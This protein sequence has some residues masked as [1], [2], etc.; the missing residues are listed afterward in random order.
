MTTLQDHPVSGGQTLPQ[1][2][3]SSQASLWRR[4]RRASPFA[5]IYSAA[6]LIFYTIIFI[7]P[8]GTGIWLAFQN[9]DF[10][11]TPKFV[12]LRNFGRAFTDQYFWWAL[13]K[14]LL[15]S[16]VEIALGLSLA[17][18]FALA[19]SQIL[20]KWQNIYL[21]LY[22]LPVITP[23]VVSLYLWRWLYRPTGGAF[24][25]L[26]S[27]LGLPEQPFLASPQQALWAIT[28]V[29]IWAHLGTGIVLFLAG[30]N[31]VPESLFEAARLDGAGFWQSFF[32]I[33][34]PLIRPV[35]VYQMVVSVIGT[36]QMFE[37]FFLIPGPG[38][39]TRTLALYTYELG[40]R[41]LNLGYGAAVSLIIFVM[42]LGAT[43]FQLRRWQ[44]QWEH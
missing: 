26:L 13:Q 38:F 1:L 12:G 34:M 37:A 42:L 31:D 16:V 36:V 27:S 33:T 30:I 5:L 18:L 28:A 4:F 8:F 24:N 25:T 35:L 15:F 40:F 23:L 32:K 3:A 20:G 14:T 19:L 6:I 39:S 21:S 2:P 11:T 9:W 22:Y 43:V 10:I 7:I 41:A 29:I 44:I 17:L